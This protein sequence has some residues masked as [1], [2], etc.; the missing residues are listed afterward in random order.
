MSVGD[1]VILPL[2]QSHDNTV[3]CTKHIW[4]CLCQ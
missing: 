2:E 3:L 4:K 1:N